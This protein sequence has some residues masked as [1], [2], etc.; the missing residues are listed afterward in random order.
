[1]RKRKIIEPGVE[2]KW[3]KSG[4][5]FPSH[6]QIKFKPKTQN[7]GVHRKPEG[8]MS[9]VYIPLCTS[10]ISPHYKTKC[11]RQGGVNTN[12]LRNDSKGLILNMGIN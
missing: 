3:A 10:L 4:I 1:M 9:V 11:V 12:Q 7:V 2:K 8:G 6:M 5:N